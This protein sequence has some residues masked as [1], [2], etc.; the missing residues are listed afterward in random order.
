MSEKTQEIKEILT[1]LGYQLKDRGAEWSCAAIFRNG[2]NQGALSINKTTG[3]YFDFV[4]SDGGSFE[5]LIEKTTGN[6]ISDELKERFASAESSVKYETELEHVKSFDKTLL[7]KLEKDYS[8]WEKRRISKFTLEKFQG[9]TTNNGRMKNRWVFPIF[10][11][12]EQLVGFSGRDLGV[13]QI[14][15]KH[16][17]E[18]SSWIFPY[19]NKEEIL[20]Q[21]S[22]ILVES[23][24]NLAA[25][26]ENGINNVLVTFGTSISSA[27]IQFLIRLNV[28][29][30]YIAFDN[31]NQKSF[32]GNLGSYKTKEKLLSYFDE[33]QIEI[34]L[35]DGFK[36]WGEADFGYIKEI[37]NEK[38]GIKKF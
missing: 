28:N 9:G 24:G 32:A 17:G 22:V 21:N 11:E 38:L 16:L 12:K 5:K 1:N 15:W 2:D 34:V 27:L 29:K 37:W 36:D 33:N 4:S 25:L 26:S 35:P 31:D 18:K 7:L 8:Y 30:I 3:Q 20:K 14:K 13:S 10:N 19:F 23:V 6:S